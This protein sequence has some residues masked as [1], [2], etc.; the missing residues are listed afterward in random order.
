MEAQAEPRAEPEAVSPSPA[1]APSA[2]ADAAGRARAEA[3]RRTRAERV[4]R[5]TEI[6]RLEA[7]LRAAEERLVGEQQAAQRA[8]E[9][10]LSAAL[11]TLATPPPTPEP[12]PPP[13]TLPPVRSGDLVEAEDPTVTPPVF[14]S[15]QSPRYPPAALALQ[16]EGSVVVEA[17]VDERGSVRE[18]RVIE[19]TTAGVGF[20]N[21]AIRQAESR[22]YRPA[23]KNGVPVRI[24]IRI[25]VT[26]TLE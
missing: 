19:S 8:S 12:V 4:R 25:R 13:T 24:W 3:R 21:A 22:R 6:Q 2:D 7:E 15:E 9:G 26:F 18:T 5:E 11:P 14:L 16:R 20:E 1:P 23:T 17:L 10:D